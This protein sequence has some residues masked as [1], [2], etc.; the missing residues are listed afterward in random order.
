[1]KIYRLDINEIENPSRMAS[2]S[3]NY[4]SPRH[5]KKSEFYLSIEKAEAKRQDIQ[6]GLSKLIGYFPS[7]EVTITPIEVIE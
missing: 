3:S 1:M 6:D 5:L 2:I 7:V 4:V